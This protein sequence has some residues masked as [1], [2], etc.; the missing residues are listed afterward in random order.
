MPLNPASL[1]SSLESLFSSPPA[2]VADCARAWAQA[3]NGYA[4]G[5]VP[6]SLPAAVNGATAALEGALAAAF[7]SATTAA[8]FDAAFAACASAIGGGMAPAYA[9]TPPA[10]PLGIAGQL[11]QSQP[12]H[13]A[14]A[15]AF[16]ALIHAWFV[17][18]FGT[19]VAPPNT[20]VFWN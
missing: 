10:A 13:A 8:D 19:L 14:A 5:I 11:A 3:I 4:A 17:T 16:A 18:G 12:T 7:G 9:A 15:A 20:I 6:P 1:Q 2:A